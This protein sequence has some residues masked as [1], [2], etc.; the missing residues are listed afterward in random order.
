MLT[1]ALQET[2]AKNE[3]L[4]ARLAAIES[5]ELVDDATDT[6]LLTLVAGLAQRVTDL[7]GGN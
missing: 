5:N 6:A 2:I 7:E 3:E 1:K 4:E